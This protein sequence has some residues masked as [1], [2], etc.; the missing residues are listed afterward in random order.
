MPA[1]QRFAPDSIV[2]APR[3]VDPGF[4]ARRGNRRRLQVFLIVFAGMLVPGLAWNLLRAPEYRAEARLQ[5]VPGSVTSRLEAA[6]GNAVVVGVESAAEDLPQQRGDLLTQ[7][8]FLTSRVVLEEASRRLAK[9]GYGDTL[10]GGD[11]VAALQSSIAVSPVAGTA[12][13]ELHAVGPSAQW[14]AKALNTLIEAYREQLLSSHDSTSQTAIG[15]LRDEVEK[16]GRSIGEK[17]SQLAAFRDKTGVVS[18]ERGENAAL[19]QYKGLSDSLSKANEEAAKAEAQVRALRESDASGDIPVRTKDDPTLASIEQRIS[20]TRE[21]LRDMERNYTAAF[22]AMDP[23]ARALR[24]RLAELEQQLVSARASSR[25]T[26]L[27]AAKADA[28]SARANVERLRG[29]IEELRRTAQAFSGKFHEAQA[30]EDDLT[31]LEGVRRN[32]TQRLA[33]LEADEN[34]RLPSLTVIEAASVPEKP[35]RPNYVRDGL[36]YLAASF[37]LALLAMWFVEL[38]NRSPP[39]PVNT[40]LFVPQPWGPPTAALGGSQVPMLPLEPELPAIPQ[41]PGEGVLPREL[42]A[43][44]VGTLLAAADGKG[45]SLCALLLLGLTPDEVRLV[46]GGD[47]DPALLCLQVRGESARTCRLPDWLARQLADGGDIG[48]PLFGNSRGE[49]IDADEVGARLTC[50]A[51]DAGLDD[52]TAVSPQVLRHTY[53]AHLI[54]QN[55]RFSDLALLA[56]KLRPEELAAYAA[57]SDGPRQARSAEV[58]PILPALHQAVAG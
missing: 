20:R 52:A 4:H 7:L 24:A 36:I 57:L 30:M 19:A 5:V 51:V 35:W 53:I 49:P 27:A 44:E 40:T 23:T 31:R 9:E 50:I 45:R 28:A 54:R 15:N 18:S 2:D 29:Q 10:G 37:L 58:D 6:G 47:C 46:V 22:M 43:D 14:S 13:V 39:A 25:Q 56:G 1:F 3:L 12:V 32:T 16:L 8:Q 42:T 17:R 26:A 48:R 33:K 11:P 38:F 55:L 41:L 21:E 34:A